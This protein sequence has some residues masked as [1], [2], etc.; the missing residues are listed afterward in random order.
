MKKLSALKRQMLRDPGTRKAYE[1]LKPEYDI[2]RELIRARTRA[3]LSQSE[4]A[5]RMGTTQSTIARMESGNHVVSISTL[6]RFA[7]A[8]GSRPVFRLLAR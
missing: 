8:T 5:Q 2:A 3:G 7:D 1:D 6:I 4:I